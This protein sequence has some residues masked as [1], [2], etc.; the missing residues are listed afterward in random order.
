MCR[1]LLP[2]LDLPVAQ[3]VHAVGRFVANH[4]ASTVSALLVPVF[5]VAGVMVHHRLRRPMASYPHLPSAESR[6]GSPTFAP[7]RLRIAPQG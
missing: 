6:S 3:I 7:R 1:H 2:H 4:P 5:V